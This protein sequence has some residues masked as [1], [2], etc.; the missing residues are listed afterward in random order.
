MVCKNRKTKNGADVLLFVDKNRIYKV[1]KM[2]AAVENVLECV[3]TELRLGKKEKYHSELSSIDSFSSWVKETFTKTNGKKKSCPS[4][5]I[6]T[7]IF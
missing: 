3:T 6:L 4:V 7:S 2:S 1:D 5:E